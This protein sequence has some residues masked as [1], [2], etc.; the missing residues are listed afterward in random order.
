DDMGLTWQMMTALS[1]APGGPLQGLFI[2]LLNRLVTAPACA[3]V[4]DDYHLIDDPAIHQGMAF[5]LDRAPPQLHLILSSRADPPLPLARLRARQQLTELRA[6]DLRFSPT[7]AAA[8]FQQ[9]ESVSLSIEQITALET[10]TEGWVAGLQLVVHSLLGQGAAAVAAFI[11]DFAG[12][13]RHVSDYLADE[14]FTGQP[15]SVR[16]F[17][18][19]TAILERFTADL[20]DAVT[21]RDDGHAVLD[22]L[23]RV[24]LFLV[25][26]DGQRRWYRYHHLFAEFLRQQL[27]RDI[28]DDELVTLHRRASQW[29]ETH[30]LMDD[31]IDHA[32]LAGDWESAVRLL[33]S[34][35]DTIQ[36]PQQYR[37]WQRWLAALPEAVLL[38][39]P[40]LC[41]EY[42]WALVLGGYL[43]ASE[44][45][46]QMAEQAWQAR[47]EE[48]QLGWVYATRAFLERTRGALPTAIE[49]AHKALASLP[50]HAA[51]GPAR[52]LAAF[53]L[54]LCYHQTGQV[55]AAE[56]VMTRILSSYHAQDSSISLGMSLILG[57][58]QVAQGQLH[59]A[60]Q[61]WTGVLRVAEESERPFAVLVARS[62]M[63]QVY[64]EWNELDQAAALWQTWLDQWGRSP[65]GDYFPGLIQRLARL[66]WAQGTEQAA[67][68]TLLQAARLARQ[69][70]NPAVAAQIEAEQVRFWLAQGDH[71]AAAAWLQSNPVS[72]YD[73][74][75]YTRQSEYLARVRVLIHR[76]QADPGSLA[77]AEQWLTGLLMQARADG[78]QGDE[79]AML[80]LQAIRASR[81]NQPDQALAA[82]E[83]ALTL[84]EPEGYVRT[85]I[86]EGEPLAGL[87]QQAASR[88]IMPAYVSR[89]LGACP[90]LQAP[91]LAEPLS[92]REIQ[93]L[94]LIAEGHATR[95]IAEILVI[96]VH[97]TRTHI[98]NIYRKLDVHSRV[99]ATKKA[100]EFGLV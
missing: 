44:S 98:K 95:Q 90:H 19:Q 54:A 84:A 3:L 35:L 62:L 2:P 33:Y 83:Q 78:R 49:L 73:E 67:F 30:G 32:L 36:R 25:P 26:L 46:L 70:G 97:T 29:Y 85:F 60:L 56:M 89:L 75:D 51:R 11:D 53:T 59:R 91:A 1:T 94:G 5:L 47:G 7:E 57:L 74:P 45:P 79:I 6:A 77:E 24:N 99:Q 61:T 65:F 72:L 81:A 23:D 48:A 14:V 28:L 66:Q 63:A 50:P 21:G 58:D 92:E 18:T 76:D 4:L 13:H 64:Y 52:S 22:H 9:L 17:L 43:T 93:I 39:D 12:S 71:A 27:E 55:R 69:L 88:G 38:A 96:S 87:L 68:A 20:C 42:A 40:R 10:R 86:D 80:V 16:Q 31:A 37:T 100:R 15:E 41:I 8:F 82:L 34:A